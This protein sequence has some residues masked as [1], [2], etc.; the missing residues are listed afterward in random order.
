MNGLPERLPYSHDQFVNRQIEIELVL[1]QVQRLLDGEPVERRTV[2]FHGQRGSGKSWLLQE[3]AH[4][5]QDQSQVLPLYLDLG[6]YGKKAPD[7]AVRGIIEQIHRSVA[8]SVGPAATG[9]HTMAD[10]D[11][12]STWLVTD[13]E[14][15]GGVLALLLDHVDES[16]KALLEP[17]EDHLLASLINVPGVKLVLA[18]RGKGYPW[19]SPPLRLKSEEYDL[20]PFE[21]THIQEQLEKQALHPTPPVDQVKQ[22]GGGF[23]WNNYLLVEYLADRGIALENCLAALLGDLLERVKP[24]LDRAYLEA[25]CVLRAF[26]DEMIPP[27]LA[28][29]FNDRAYLD[30]K[31]GQYRQVRQ[32]LVGTT[33]AKWDSSSGSYVIDKALCCVLEHWLYEAHQEVYTCLHTAACDLFNKW[34]NQYPRTADRWQKE[35]AYHAGKLAHGP[36]WSSEEKEEGEK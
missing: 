6:E 27:M 8:D 34:T 31:Y 24:P 23:P 15:M 22:W 25:L 11:R 2:I 10:L 7:D 5:L 9:F 26:S 35:A 1:K 30:W 29:Y 28:A 4:R 32:S 12:M 17:L 36:A 20:G 33:L 19:K 3:I 14:Q 13:V 21:E 16:D 18:G